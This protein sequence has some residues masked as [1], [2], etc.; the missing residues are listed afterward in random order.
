MLTE[1][2]A[3]N[4]A[5][6][7]GNVLTN[8]LFGAD[9]PGTKTVTS[10]ED[11]VLG[12]P[13][14]GHYGELTLKADGSYTYQLTPG[15]NVPKGET[16]TETFTYTIT[17]TDGD[18]SEA[19]LTITITGDERTP[20]ISV[21]GAG[22]A[23]ATVYES[24]LDEGGSEASTDKETTSGEISLTLNG[25]AATVTIGGHEFAV[26][27]DGNANIAADGESIDT[28]EGTLV[29]TDISGGKVSYTYTRTGQQ[30]A[31]GRDRHQR[32][33]CDGR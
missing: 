31:D 14:Q 27:A 13:V 21:P 19:T 18:T 24:G 9:E 7:N 6:D 17:D 32:E 4:G 20:S 5:T 33:G 12:Q 16:V 10:I 15:V 8:D 3:Q 22:D 29:I 23:S 30:H 2:A 28:G 11:G 1:A 26:D 25:E